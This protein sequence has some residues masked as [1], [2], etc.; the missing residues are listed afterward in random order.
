MLID[1]IDNQDHHSDCKGTFQTIED[2]TKKSR[3]FKKLLKEHPHLK[4]FAENT[5]IDIFQVNAKYVKLLE[6]VS[7]AYYE[8]LDWRISGIF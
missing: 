4:G 6:R 5:E 3:I 7:N 1:L 8:E 2:E